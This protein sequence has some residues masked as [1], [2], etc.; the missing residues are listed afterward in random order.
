MKKKKKQ[1]TLSLCRRFTTFY[2]YRFFPFCEVQAVFSDSNK[3]RNTWSRARWGNSRNK[4]QKTKTFL[5]P[6]PFVI[7]FK[8]KRLLSM[9]K[10]TPLFVDL[11]SYLLRFRINGFTIC[12]DMCMYGMLGK[13][14]FSFFFPAFR[15]Y[16]SVFLMVFYEYK[17]CVNGHMAFRMWRRKNLRPSDFRFLIPVAH[18]IPWTYRRT[19]E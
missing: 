1:K 8:S 9:T 5:F 3:T 12:E 14:T 6:C 16:F 11:F 13:I 4:R 18:S 10:H 7:S 17:L 15:F 19:L 2:F